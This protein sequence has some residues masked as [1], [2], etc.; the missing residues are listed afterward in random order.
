VEDF[1]VGAHN[2]F[3]TDAV[4]T[5]SL[6]HNP[7]DFSVKLSTELFLSAILIIRS[8]TLGPALTTEAA[9]DRVT[10]GTQ[11]SSFELETVETEESVL[12]VDCRFHCGMTS[13]SN[14]ARISFVDPD[15]VFSCLGTR[16]FEYSITFPGSSK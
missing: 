1:G 4:Q 15:N 6:D 3:P 14:C 9:L 7:L 12:P 8:L 10:L 5:D 16:R 11:V 2:P 13:C